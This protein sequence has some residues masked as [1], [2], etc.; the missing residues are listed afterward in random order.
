MKFGKPVHSALGNG[1]TG[2]FRSS[3]DAAGKQALWSRDD[4][5]QR[6][7]LNLPRERLLD[8][9]CPRAGDLLHAGQGRSRHC[10]RRF[11]DCRRVTV[12]FFVVFWLG[13]NL[14]G[15]SPFS[16]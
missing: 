11:G 12:T 10:D 8:R 1:F 15:N 16:A 7:R 14:R 6:L 2:A 5:N 3:A 13:F 4:C 9:L